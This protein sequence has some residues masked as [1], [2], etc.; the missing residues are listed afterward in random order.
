MEDV[1]QAVENGKNLIAHAPTGLGKTAGVLT[2]ALQYALDNDK[3]VFFLT[4]RHSQHMMAIDTLKKM[5][6]NGDFMAADL[7]GKK[8]MCSAAGINELPHSDFSSYCAHVR[9]KRTCDFYTKTVDKNRELTSMAK[10]KIKEIDE[11]KESEEIKK[12]FSRFCPYEI[13]V[14]LMK[15]SKAVVCDYFHVFSSEETSILKKIDV[16]LEDCV[17]IVDE[18]HNLPTRLRSMMSQR[19]STYILSN[20]IDEAEELEFWQ[21]ENDLKEIYSE[22]K[23]LR[24]DVEDECFF[25]K[26]GLVR[27]IER[28]CDYDELID[29]LEEGVDRVLEEKKRSFLDSIA[30]FLKEWRGED[31]GFARILRSGDKGYLSLDYVCLDPSLI[32][33]NVIANA[34][35]TI[36]MSGTMK[37]M[38][39]YE[40]L[41]GMEESRTMS[42][43]YESDFPE[44]NRKVVVYPEVTSKYS[45]RDSDQYR[46]IADTVED[47]VQEI[48]GNSIVFFPSYSFLHNVE[49]KMD[50]NVIVENSDWDKE[51]RNQVIDRF[52]DSDRNTLFGVMGGSFYEGIDL[53][54]DALNGVII[55]GVPLANPDLEIK[56]TINYYKEKFDE[57]WNYAYLYPALIKVTQSCGRL[58]RSKGDRGVAVLM[59]NRYLRSKYKDFFSAWNLTATEE[60]EQ[61]IKDF[62][63]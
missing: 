2:P 54:G 44:E 23:E 35:S 11:P 55:V 63:S 48:P 60:P 18:A 43:E 61:E 57:G 24:D 25:P 19:L 14:E 38:E 28:I 22:F 6:Q 58:I 15:R 39:M 27:K 56:S 47:C 4:N 1:E 31:E 13:T 17:V 62:F 50:R 36:L 29:R 45:Q 8:H 46:K 59:D 3:H 12:N 5:A 42:R 51:E 16:G 37:P 52:R 26:K 34:H 30:S 7:I 41:L 9:K 49:L 33:S 32:S 10:K 21:L 40:D 53:P 20:A